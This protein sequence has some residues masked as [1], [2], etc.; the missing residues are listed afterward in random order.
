MS[1]ILRPPTV[2]ELQLVINKKFMINLHHPHIYRKTLDLMRFYKSLR[3]VILKKLIRYANGRLTPYECC[4]YYHYLLCNSKFN[5]NGFKEM[6]MALDEIQCID[7][8]GDNI[9]DFKSKED[10]MKWIMACRIARRYIRKGHKNI[11]KLM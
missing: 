6:S 11:D 10:A 1:Y 5:S 8:D 2:E 4:I 9:V 7:N 3:A